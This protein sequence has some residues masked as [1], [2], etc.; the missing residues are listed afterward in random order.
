MSQSNTTDITEMNQSDPFGKVVNLS[1]LG[2]S[3]YE[4][5]LLD[6]NLNFLV[7]PDFLNKKYFLRDINKFNRRVKL[8]S[9]FGALP[10]KKEIFFKSNSIWETTK[11]HHTVKT[12][13]ETR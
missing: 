3:V 2:L 9:N 1:N 11:V 6:Y 5:K 4:Y 12:F 13:I 10:N 7:T 8:K